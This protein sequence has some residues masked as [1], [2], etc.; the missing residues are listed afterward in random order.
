MCD[1]VGEN[2]ALVNDLEK[3]AWWKTN[4]R[5]L[6]KLAANAT[7]VT[8]VC[9]LLKFFH[10]IKVPNQFVKKISVVQHGKNQATLHA[11]MQAAKAPLTGPIYKQFLEVLSVLFYII[12]KQV[13]TLEI[14]NK[15]DRLGVVDCDLAAGLSNCTEVASQQVLNAYLTAYPAIKGKIAEEGRVTW[16]YLSSLGLPVSESNADG[17]ADKSQLACI[18]TSDGQRR[19]IA[20]RLEQKEQKKR[21]AAAARE[22]AEEKVQQ[23]LRNRETKK[24]KGKNHKSINTNKAREDIRG[25]SADAKLTGPDDV[26]CLSCDAKWSILESKADTYHCGMRECKFCLGWCCWL[27]QPTK[28]SFERGHETSC[29]TVQQAKAMMENFAA[30]AMELQRQRR[31]EQ[32]EEE[33]DEDAHNDDDMEDEER[34]EESAPDDDGED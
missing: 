5:E 32:Q 13:K 4:R 25:A 9:D 34:R 2:L 20:G 16:A 23:R 6:L 22:A 3:L 8:Q 26:K 7:H 31:A 12:Y 15:F 29:R 33:Q 10:W 1:G 18:L 27:C 11:Q 19:I 21:T 14:V 30:R 28:E 17:K 24:E